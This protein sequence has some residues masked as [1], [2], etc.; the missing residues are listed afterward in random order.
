M[1]ANLASFLFCDDAMVNSLVA[2]SAFT[3]LAAAHVM[4]AANH[5]SA[6]YGMPK[7]AAR[8]GAAG[9]VVSRRVNCALPQVRVPDTLDTLARFSPAWGRSFAG[10]V[11]GWWLSSGGGTP[12]VPGCQ[13]VRSFVGRARACPRSERAC[14][15]W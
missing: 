3:V 15:A 13:R 12:G 10:V 6:I 11:V 1:N 2:N 9:A 7:A 14:R 5:T 8:L 4:R